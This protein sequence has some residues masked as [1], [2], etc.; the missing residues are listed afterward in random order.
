MRRIVSL[1]K[2]RLIYI[3]DNELLLRDGNDCEASC[4]NRKYE[5]YYLWWFPSFSSIDEIVK[6]NSKFEDVYLKKYKEM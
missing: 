3:I 5:I 4:N 2:D 1:E 6:C